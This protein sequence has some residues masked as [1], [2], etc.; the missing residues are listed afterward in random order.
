MFSE[1][2]LGR[3]EPKTFEH[4]EKYPLQTAVDAQIFTVPDTLEKSLGL[5]SYWK[6]WDQGEEGACVGFG[7]SAMMGITNTLQYRNHLGNMAGEFAFEPFWLYREAQLV[8]EWPETP[9]EE[10]TSVNASC[11]VLLSQGHRRAYRNSIGPV[12]S[13]YGIK[14][15]RWA[16][17]VDEMR[18]AIHAGLAVSIGVNWYTNFD[19]LVKENGEHWIGVDFAGNP[20]RNL[21]KIRGGH[22]VCVYRASD[23]RQ[24]FRFM[25]SWGEYYPPT[26]IPYN[27]M[28]RLLYEY[29]EAVVITDR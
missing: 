6:R 11:K 19:M 20:T 28:Q 7:S 4:V 10:G 27:V 23:K 17:T 9:P 5:P 3:R 29:G 24:A 14:A 15:Y 13:N 12:E 18:A 8:D 1:G 22:S 21:G 26:W 16:K 25:N 2:A